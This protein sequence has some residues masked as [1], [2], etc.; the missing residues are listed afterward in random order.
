MNHGVTFE[1]PRRSSLAEIRNPVLQLPSAQRILRLDPEVRTILAEL[2]REL[3]TEARARAELA[4]RRHKAPMAVYWRATATIANHLAKVLR[5]PPL[6][7]TTPQ[8]QCD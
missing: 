6:S 1:P 8:P 3:A 5:R 7:Q 4:W 2:L